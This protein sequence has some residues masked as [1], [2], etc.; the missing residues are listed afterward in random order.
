MHL[1]CKKETHLSRDLI[2]SVILMCTYVTTIK[3]SITVIYCAVERK[4]IRDVMVS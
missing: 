1:Y 4:A 2:H 3:R